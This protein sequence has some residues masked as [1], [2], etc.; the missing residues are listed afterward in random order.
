VEGAPSHVRFELEALDDGAATRL[1]LEH[2]L[3]AAEMTAGYGAGWHAH[4]D[5]LE[6]YLQGEAG[7]WRERFDALLP[8]YRER[9]GATR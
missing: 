9:A 2:T 8:A 5:Q 4:L 3:L 1:T 7:P 6:G